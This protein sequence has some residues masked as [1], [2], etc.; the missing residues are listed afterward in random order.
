MVEFMFYFVF[1]ILILKKTI[2]NYIFVK[3]E[4]VH[5][6]RMVMVSV[7]GYLVLSAAD[8]VY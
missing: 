8:Q 7:P 1:S 2:Y 6:S 3:H 4:Q 5:V